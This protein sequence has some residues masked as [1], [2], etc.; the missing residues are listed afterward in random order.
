MPGSWI[1]YSSKQIQV[2]GQPLEVQ[3]NGRNENLGH[4]VKVVVW[5]PDDDH[6]FDV[7]TRA[8]TIVDS[9]TGRSR[10]G[11]GQLALQERLEKAET[12]ATRRA[13]TGDWAR[14]GVYEVQGSRALPHAANQA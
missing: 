2:D 9:A 3:V 12:E 14:G 11:A 10:S 4:T 7:V 13:Q 6:L 5:G 1:V 8:P